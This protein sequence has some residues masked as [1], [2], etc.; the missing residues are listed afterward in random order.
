MKPLTFNGW[1]LDKIN[2]YLEQHEGCS[3][4]NNEDTPHESRAL[5]QDSLGFVYEVT[6]KTLRR[7]HEPISNSKPVRILE[8]LK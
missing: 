1:I 5:I 8:R 4:H 6:V 7:S 2:A 3:V